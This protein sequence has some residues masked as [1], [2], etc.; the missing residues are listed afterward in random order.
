MVLPSVTH[1]SF[2][3]LFLFCHRTDARGDVDCC[4]CILIHFCHQCCG[5]GSSTFLLPLPPPLS[6]LLLPL[7]LPLTLPLPLSLSLPL[8]CRC[9]RC[10]AAAAFWW[11]NSPP[12]PPPPP[13]PFMTRKWTI[14][15]RRRPPPCA[16]TA[17]VAAK[18]RGRGG[19]AV[20]P[21]VGRPGVGWRRRWWWSGVRVRVGERGQQR[22][23]GVF[24]S[25]WRAIG[26]EA[27]EPTRQVEI[28]K[29]STQQQHYSEIDGVFPIFLSLSERRL[30]SAVMESSMLV[31]VILHPPT[32]FSLSR[33]REHEDP[34]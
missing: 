6:P 11:W 8:H 9:L 2:C 21:P 5:S 31:V 28:K 14:R 33:V 15:R 32:D 26:D 27:Q 22:R 19:V 20:C 34:P 16:M 1:T 4:L 12:P 25:F 30:P 17:V 13:P 7:P 3:S 23:P 24:F 10:A 18:K 29:R